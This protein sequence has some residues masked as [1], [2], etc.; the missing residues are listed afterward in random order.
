MTL[1]NLSAATRLVLGVRRLLRQ[2][3]TPAR[4]RAVLEDR[5]RRHES[6]FLQTILRIGEAD[7]AGLY[8]RLLASAGCA[9][10]DVVRLVRLE[11]VEGALRTLARH[12]VYLTVEEFK[13]RRAVVRGNVIFQINPERSRLGRSGPIAAQTSG[14]RGRRSIVA[15]DIDA[16]WAWAVDA[17]LDYEARGGLDW[18]HGRW[19][20]PGG[21]SIAFLLLF[22]AF[23][24]VPVRWF[25]PLDPAA[26]GLHARYRWSARM[27]PLA[28]WLGGARLPRPE[29]VPLDDPEPVAAWLA[30]VRRRGRTPH[31]VTYASSAVRVCEAALAR[32]LDICGTRFSVT[33]EPITAARLAAI[34]KAGA[35]AAPYYGSV[36]AGL[37][38][39]GCLAPVAPDEVHVHDDLVT[40]VQPDR[41]DPVTGLRPDHLLVSS[42]RAEAPLVLLNV[43]L[44]DEGIL[45]AR[46]CGCPLETVGWTR[47]LHA[48]RSFEKLTAGG[49]TFLDCD[50]VRV[51]EEE[52]PGRFGGGPT[53]YQLLEEE[54]P[55]GEPRLRLLVHPRVGCLSPDVVADTFLDAIGT[56]N[57]AERVMALHWRQAGLLRVERT[58]PLTTDSGKI[59]HLHRRPAVP[60]GRH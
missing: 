2:P 26:G 40:L 57:G 60:A 18:V 11:G 14:S 44:G 47:H 33:G 58:P 34:R 25:S 48:I 22:C 9:Y 15:I 31:L 16:I 24:A 50:V 3:V 23:G 27:L 4:A 54:A 46:R 41:A 8:A 7:R 17:C 30:A 39:A 35:E 36:D 52:L 42:F 43:S 53:D 20:V 1:D 59:L 28:G 51:L 45:D 32:D 49:M 21:D 38:G 56:G 5:R 29:H 13:G 12:G 10:G 37:I 6:D 19:T 55:G